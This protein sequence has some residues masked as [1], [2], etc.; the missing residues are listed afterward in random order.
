[1]RISR[2]TAFLIVLC[3]AVLSAFWWWWFPPASNRERV[4]AGHPTASNAKKITEATPNS[5]Q[6]A[7]HSDDRVQD[8]GPRSPE[9]RQSFD[10]VLRKN[11]IATLRQQGGVEKRQYAVNLNHDPKYI[12][13][14][15]EIGVDEKGIPELISLIHERN[16]HISKARAEF[17]SLN[18]RSS[19]DIQAYL[20]LK[21]GFREEFDKKI[22]AQLGQDHSVESLR[23]WERK[24]GY[25]GTIRIE[26]Q[27]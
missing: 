7:G 13:Y 22:Q 5:P 27:E 9:P 2:N 14:F 19:N 17:F 4:S 20:V 18:G 21:D 1:M 6:E 3:V 24:M 16:L 11:S 12:Q 8:K 25:E 23:A 10:Q 15:R 26:K